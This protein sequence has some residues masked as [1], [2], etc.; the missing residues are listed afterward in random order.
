M[1]FN[2]RCLILIVIFSEYMTEDYDF[3]NFFKKNNG[4]EC[5]D[6]KRMVDLKKLP[7]RSQP[8]STFSA[9]ISNFYSFSQLNLDCFAYEKFFILNIDLI[10]KKLIVLENIEKLAFKFLVANDSQL[11]ISFVF[12]KGIDV[13]FNLFKS[14]SLYYQNLLIFKYFQ[15]IVYN[16]GTKVKFCDKISNFAIKK[17]SITLFY[18][19]S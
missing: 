14:K 7:L 3:E 9:T 16:N 1:Y 19:D 2:F 5:F 8:L 11:S 15:L 17:C 10:P 18:S 4:T 6:F 13:N 12:F